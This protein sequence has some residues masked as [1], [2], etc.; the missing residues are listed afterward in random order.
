MDEPTYTDEQLAAAIEFAAQMAHEEGGLPCLFELEGMV[1]QPA[2]W[3]AW[4]SQQSSE[5]PMPASM[6][7]CDLHKRQ[8]QAA[9]RMRNWPGFS[10]PPCSFC[11]HPSLFERF[12]PI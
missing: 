1:C 3:I 2:L 6:P 8:A 4:T 5:C 9:Y 12:T 10:P 7:M 11:G